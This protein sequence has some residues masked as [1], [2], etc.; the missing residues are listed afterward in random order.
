MSTIRFSLALGACVLALQSSTPPAHAQSA[1]T[2]G[3][4]GDGKALAQNDAAAVA[5]IDHLIQGNPDKGAATQS[6]NEALDSPSDALRWHAARAAGHLR[7]SDPAVVAKLQNGAGDDNW[8]V[9][10]HSISALAQSG[11]KTDRTIEVLTD[12]ALSSK[13]RVAAASIAALRKLQVSPEK[14]A[15][16]LN[17]VLAGDNGAV[18]IYA[19]EAMVDAGAKAVPLLKACLKEPNS[20]YWACLAIADIGPDAAGT[21]PELGAFVSSHDKAEAIPQALMA[22]AAIGPAAKSVEASIVTAMEHWADDQSVQ[23]S[24]MYALGAINATDARQVL[25]QRA[26][27]D[28]PFEAMVASWALAKTNPGDDQLLD[29]AVKRLVGGLQSDSPNMAHAAAHG[30]AT[31]EMPEGTAAPYLLE[32]A[33]NPSAREHVLTALASLGAEGIPH[34]NKALANPETRELAVDVLARMGS[35]AEGATSALVACMD[36]AE[37]SVS[38]QINYVLA[39]IGPSAAVAAEK[40]AAQ[41]NSSNPLV[42]QSAMYALR[43]IG[44]AAGSAKASLLSHLTEVDSSSAQD[45]FEQLASAWTL[46]RIAANDPAVQ[47]AILPI[48]QNGLASESEL[49]RR[50]SIA[51]TADL[52]AAA[53]ALHSTVAEMASSDPSASVREVAVAVVERDN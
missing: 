9:Q 16:T 42:R 38:V 4:T 40:L 51:A 24:G 5:A 48:I 53:S 29:S 19:V 18:A 45:R 3:T 39:N 26:S 41:L 44:P 37:P 7:L 46:A 34:A 11:D 22:L 43:E 25:D 8:V 52:G 23:L 15:A 21:V 10:L 50:E 14:L 35:Q 47:K 12:G 20:A 31:L 28:D 49:E 32:A 17:K 36:A 30:L 2:A 33:K 13:T 1:T 6:I 27:S